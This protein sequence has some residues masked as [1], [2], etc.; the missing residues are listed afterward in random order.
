MCSVS[1]V[2]YL[3]VGVGLRVLLFPIFP[4]SISYLLTVC[5]YIAVF[6]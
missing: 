5:E 6:L 4:S 2:V 3:I 1:G